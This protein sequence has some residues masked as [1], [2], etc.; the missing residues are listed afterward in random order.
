MTPHEFIVF[1]TTHTLRHLEQ[2]AEIQNSPGY[3]A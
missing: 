1:M 3:P 2:I